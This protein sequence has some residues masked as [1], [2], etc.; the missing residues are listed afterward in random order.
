MTIGYFEKLISTDLEFLA[1]LMSKILL[2]PLI[3]V[4]RCVRYNKMYSSLLS[5]EVTT[6]RPKARH[7]LILFV[8]VAVLDIF[9]SIKL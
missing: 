5:H 6:T 2:G 8:G 9:Y 7:F 1:L 3:I 4:K